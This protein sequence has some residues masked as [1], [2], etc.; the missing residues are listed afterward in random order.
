[1]VLLQHLLVKLKRLVFIFEDLFFRYKNGREIK[2]SPKA[3]QTQ[4]SPTKYELSIPTA[5]DNDTAVFKVI[6]NFY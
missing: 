5:S 6:K 3:K 4:I 2:D 1:M